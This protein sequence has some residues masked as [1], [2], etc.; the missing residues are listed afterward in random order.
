M[1]FIPYNIKS[2]SIHLSPKNINSL[3][4]HAAYIKMILGFSAF[5]EYGHSVLRLLDC[6]EINKLVLING[7]F[8]P[9]KP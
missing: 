7:C 4:R 1:V 9:I 5:N 3:S 2:L 6:K 8:A